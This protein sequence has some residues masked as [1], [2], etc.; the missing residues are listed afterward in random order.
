MDSNVQSEIEK[1]GAIQIVTGDGSCGIYS[2]IK[3]LSQVMIE[4]TMNVNTFRE[5]VY[6]Y[7]RSNKSSNVLSVAFTN[8]RKKSGELIGIIRNEYI[9]RNAM[10]IIW[11]KYIG[12]QGQADE[13]CW[14]DSS[15][16]LSVF[17]SIYKT[18]IIWYDVN[19]VMA[20]TCTLKNTRNKVVD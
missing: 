6:N 11:S 9:E 18:H 4:C 2:V 19:E 3:G 14:V 15:L 10:K 20:Y 8:K 17:V 13:E 16:Y 1:Y 12:F 5:E 7:D